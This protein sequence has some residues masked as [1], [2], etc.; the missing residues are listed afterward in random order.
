MKQMKANGHI[1]QE[2]NKIVELILK[3]VNQLMLYSR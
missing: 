1:D 3:G 2:E